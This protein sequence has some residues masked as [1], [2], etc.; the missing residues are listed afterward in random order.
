[1]ERCNE[2][3]TKEATGTCAYCD[4]LTERDRF[5]RPFWAVVASCNKG[6]RWVRAHGSLAFLTVVSLGFLVPLIYAW[7][8]QLD[9]RDQSITC[10]VSFRPLKALNGYLE[11]QLTEHHPSE[12]VFSGKLFFLSVD[13]SDAGVSAVTVS[14]SQKRSYAGSIRYIRTTWDNNWK[15]LTPQVPEE[16]A[17]VTVTGSHQNFPRDSARFD[18]DLDVNPP[19]DFRVIRIVN[20]VPGFVMDCSTL[21]VSSPNARTLHINFGLNRSLIIQL[22]TGMLVV[23]SIGFLVLILFTAQ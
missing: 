9:Q 21:Q 2:L 17:L 23:A 12:P 7:W 18:F 15:A 3:C 11:I 19:I 4:T 16:F 22:F 14:R 8:L 5:E 6:L 20:R 13:P 1:M 10:Q